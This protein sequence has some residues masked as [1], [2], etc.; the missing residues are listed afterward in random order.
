M[1]R[2]HSSDEPARAGRGGAW[3]G[4]EGRGGA[5]PRPSLAARTDWEAACR[6]TPRRT[7]RPPPWPPRLFPLPA[8]AV[9][10]TE[11]SAVGSEGPCLGPRTTQGTSCLRGGTCSGHALGGSRG[12]RVAGGPVARPSV[13]VRPASSAGHRPATPPPRHSQCLQTVQALEA[14]GPQALDAVVMEVP[15]WGEGTCQAGRPQPRPGQG[16]GGG[17][18]GTVEAEAPTDGPSAR[19][20]GLQRHSDWPDCGS[21]TLRGWAD[22]G[23]RRSEFRWRG[24]EFP[25]RS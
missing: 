21:H 18:S 8:K 7:P 12:G 16:A 24:K 22:R 20:L 4:A 3:R 23:L 14:V 2:K 19:A 15:V 6:E 5:S 11:L 25:G 13:H 17:W 9:I 10:V 1:P